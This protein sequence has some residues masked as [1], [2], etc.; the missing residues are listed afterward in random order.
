MTFLLGVCVLAAG[1]S[2]FKDLQ[3]TGSPIA[4][5]LHPLKKSIRKLPEDGSS[6]KK[7]DPKNGGLV[8]FRLYSIIIIVTLP[9]GCLFID[10]YF[11]L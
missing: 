8:L 1:T 10:V 7:V 11:T 9:H 5:A 2:V 3:Q 6:Q 4:I